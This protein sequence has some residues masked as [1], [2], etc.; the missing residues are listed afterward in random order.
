ME[1]GEK[2]YPFQEKINLGRHS[3]GYHPIPIY[4][5]LQCLQCLWRIMNKLFA[6]LNSL[7]CPR[8]QQIIYMQSVK[9]QINQEQNQQLSESELLPF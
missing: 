7:L 6:E 8:A 3:P 4:L 2:G 9:P 5:N 1:V